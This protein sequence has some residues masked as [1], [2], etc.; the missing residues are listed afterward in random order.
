M[1]SGTIV[2]AALC[3]LALASLGYANMR[4]YAPFVVNAVTAAHAASP[5]L[6]HK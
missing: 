3:L 5:S 2:Y 1:K 6:F 4:G